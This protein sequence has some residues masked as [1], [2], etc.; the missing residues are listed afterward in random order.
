MNRIRKAR[1]RAAKSQHYHCYYCGKPMAADEQ[2]LGH[3]AR[4][5]S[6]GRK[7]AKL[8]VATAEHL[9]P[10]CEGGTCAGNNIVA[11]HAICNH[12]RHQ[13]SKAPPPDQ[14][15]KL[16]QSRCEKGGWHDPA[17]LKL[18]SLLPPLRTQ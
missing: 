1:A 9:K 5:N 14:Y 3:F 17:V 4:K 15:R 11:A 10:R 18:P 6:L 2:D 13:R 8:L 7:Q 16:V 12:R